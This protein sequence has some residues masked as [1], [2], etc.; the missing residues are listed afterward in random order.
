VSYESFLKDSL[1][2]PSTNPAHVAAREVLALRARVAELEEGNVRRQV[3]LEAE[4]DAARAEMASV[5]SELARLFGEVREHHGMTWW[6]CMLARIGEHLADNER[7]CEAL[8]EFVPDHFAQCSV[9]CICQ[10]RQQKARAALSGAQG[11]T[12]FLDADALDATSDEY[13]LAHGAP[14]LGGRGNARTVTEEPRRALEEK[15]REACAVRAAEYDRGG[16]LS[17]FHENVR[18]AIRALDL[19]ALIN[20]S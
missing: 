16:L 17:E 10:P 2:F 1:K 4:R 12:R 20:K 19:D 3:A 11:E 6:A 18:D 8:R 7:L 5:R 14:G 15:V 9:E 13:L